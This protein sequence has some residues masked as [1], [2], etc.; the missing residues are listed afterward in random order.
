[1]NKY[2]YMALALLVIVLIFVTTVTYYKNKVKRLEGKIETLTMQLGSCNQALVFQNAEVEKY[3]LDIENSLVSY[4]NTKQDI[5]NK[6]EDALS[7]SYITLGC[8]EQI[9]LLNKNQKE[10]L[11]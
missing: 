2:V 10:Y 6:Y 5:I 1:M 3:K 4:E 8:E 9:R 11:K 7:K